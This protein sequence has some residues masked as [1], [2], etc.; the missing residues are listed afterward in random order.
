MEVNILSNGSL[1]QTWVAIFKSDKVDFK[2]KLLSR[3]KECYD[4][5]VR[6]WSMK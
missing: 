5:L 2:P 1:K 4:I 3:D 6:E